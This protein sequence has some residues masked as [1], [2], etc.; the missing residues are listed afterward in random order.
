MDDRVL[1]AAVNW[2]SIVHIGEQIEWLVR[3]HAAALEIGLQDPQEGEV[4]V[5]LD[6]VDDV[7]AERAL[8]ERP[9]TRRV[10]HE[11][12]RDFG[13]EDARVRTAGA[14][15]AA[16]NCGTVIVDLVQL[17][18]HARAHLTALSKLA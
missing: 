5:L 4:L 17:V 11:S 18:D 2:D 14:L 15:S 8:V 9:R 16:Q 3:A 13:A 6:L 12:L 10:S 7:R 1:A